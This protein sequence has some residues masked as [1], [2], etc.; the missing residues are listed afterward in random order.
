MATFDSES[1]KRQEV[2]GPH[3][4]HRSNDQYIRH[5]RPTA[6]AILSGHS[7]ARTKNSSF[8]YYTSKER[9]QFDSSN[10]DSHS[11][12]GLEKIKLIP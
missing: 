5:T 10:R 7:V 1:N 11:G 12:D 9:I 2:I 6:A 8:E 4:S 3:H